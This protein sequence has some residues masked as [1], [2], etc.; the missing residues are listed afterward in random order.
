MS[1]IDAVSTPYTPD[2][3]R[4]KLIGHLLELQQFWETTDLTAGLLNQHGSDTAARLYGLAFSIMMLL[5]GSTFNKDLPAFALIPTPNQSDEARR[6]ETSGRYWPSCTYREGYQT[7][8]GTPISDDLHATYAHMFAMR[9]L[10]AERAALTSTCRSATSAANANSE[11]FS[12]SQSAAG[13]SRDE[14]NVFAAMAS[15]P[16]TA[17]TLDPSLPLV[18]HFHGPI[19]PEKS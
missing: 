7:L 5:D 10:A 1:P 2:E 14:R 3:M 17:L 15:D 12:D 11:Q 8:T 13:M 19:P 16:K 9:K 4:E 18:R 6:Q